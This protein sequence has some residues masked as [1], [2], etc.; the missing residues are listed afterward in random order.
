MDP[1]FLKA[2]ELLDVPVI[3]STEYR[4]YYDADGCVVSLSERDHPTGD[5]I[6]LDDPKV[7]FN[8]NT[9]LLR[10]IDNRLVVLTAQL[11][12]NTGLQR[13]TQ[14][15]RVVKGIATLALT[16]SEEYQDIEYYDRKTNN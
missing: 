9:R 16:D 13:S 1:E 2:L 4:L 12:S 8:T 11:K 7:F 15:Q 5:Y 3:E 6:V 10:V 14:G